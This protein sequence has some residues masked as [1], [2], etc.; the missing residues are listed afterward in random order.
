MFGGSK[1]FLKTANDVLQTKATSKKA[2]SITHAR[3]DLA[4]VVTHLW[5]L[6]GFQFQATFL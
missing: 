2:D 3:L 1:Y 5:F 6:A 4:Q